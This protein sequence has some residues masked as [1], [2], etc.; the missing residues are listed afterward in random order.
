MCVC[1]CVCH[2]LCVC[3]LCVVFIHDRYT[4]FIVSCFTLN[5]SVSMYSRMLISCTLIS[6]FRSKSFAVATRLLVR[7]VR[8]RQES[9]DERTHSKESA[10]KRTRSIEIK[11]DENRITLIAIFRSKSF[12]VATRL[13]GRCACARARAC[14]SRGP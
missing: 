14:V 6:F 1:V 4:Q 13:L 2:K 10:D 3:A 7:C 9:T 8:V 12:A 11:S 5:T